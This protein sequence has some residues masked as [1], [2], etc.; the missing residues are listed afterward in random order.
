MVMA[1]KEELEGIRSRFHRRRTKLGPRARDLSPLRAK[2]G[3]KCRLFLTTLQ[4]SGPRGGGGRIFWW[5]S[6][7]VADDD[8][9]QKKN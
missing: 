3:N 9:I 1:L 4:R 5:E 2:T 6:L 8:T 7:S